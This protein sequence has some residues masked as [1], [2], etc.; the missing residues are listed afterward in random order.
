MNLVRVGLLA[1]R[2]VQST[3][4]PTPVEIV[5]AESWCLVTKLTSDVMIS[6]PGWSLKTMDL[7]VLAF[8][9]ND[10]VF[11]LRT[12]AKQNNALKGIE[13]ESQLSR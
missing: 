8:S 12:P 6:S 10:L 11:V 5:T 2:I 3:V 13:E 1:S 9:T 4:L 7:I